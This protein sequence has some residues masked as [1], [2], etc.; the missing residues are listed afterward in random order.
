[1]NPTITAKTE[2][3]LKNAQPAIRDELSRHLA[4]CDFTDPNDPMLNALVVQS[5]IAGQPVRLV[6]HGGAAVATEAG[7]ARLG[8]RF[9]NTAWSLARLRIGTI[10]LACLL[11]SGIGA[12]GVA[13]AFKFWGAS[14]AGF[15]DLPR[16]TDVRL[17]ILKDIGAVLEVEQRQ[18]TT[19]LYFK[20]QMQP[21]AQQ[22]KNGTNFLYFK[23]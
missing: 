2:S 5:T 17:G 10:A 9:E 20:G 22:T 13:L 19:Y 15:F 18:G 1:M 4:A 23:P 21:A 6:E 8:N 11:S 16:A 3:I 14:L 12:G 7:L